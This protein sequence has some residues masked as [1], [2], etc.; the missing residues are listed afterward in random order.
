MPKQ[1]LMPDILRTHLQSEMI[2]KTVGLF[3]LKEVLGVGNT[4]VT[5]RADDSYG[6]P[7]AIKMVTQVSYG[8]RAPLREIAR[9]AKATDERFLVFPKEVGNYSLT[10]RRKTHEF[11]WFRSRI[12]VGETLKA[13]LESNTTFSAKSEILSF[14]ENLTVAID[15]LQKL[16]FSHGD[17][18]DR[19]IMR[20]VIGENGP[21]PEVRYVVIDFSEAHALDS[22]EEGL[23]KD[24]ENLGRHLRGFF[25]AVSQRQ[26]VTRGDEKALAAIAHIPGLLH[27]TAPESMGITKASDV[28]DRFKDGLRSAE[29]A[30]RVL[31]TPFD[32]L[33]SE[34][35]ANNALLAD[36]CFTKSWWASE[37]E[38]NKN[39]LLIGPRGCGKTMIFRRLRLKTKIAAKKT[40]EVKSDPYVGFYL[41]CESLF[42]MRF[43]DLSEAGIDDYKEA[44]ILFFNMAVLAEICSTLAELPDYMAPVPHSAATSIAKLLKEEI[45]PLWED[46]R[47]PA[48]PP[49]LWELA[50]SADRVMR[51]IRRSIAYGEPIYPRGSTEFVSLLVRAVKRE[52][53]SL[54]GRCFTFF[55]DDYTEERVPIGL[56]EALHPIISQRSA[57]I[58]FK[59]SAHM[60]GSI[61]SFPRPLALDEGRNII[62]INL[63]SAYLNLDKRKKQG[64]LLLKILDERFRHCDG[65]EGQTE[66]WL[67]KTTYPDG[68]TLARTLHDEDTRNKFHYHGVDCLMELCTGDYSEMIRMVGDIFR[69]AGVEPGEPVRTISPYL[70]DKAITRVSREFLGRIRHIRPD[71][72]KLF[73]VVYNFG[74]LSQRLL[75]ER[76]PVGQGLDRKGQPRKDPYDLLTVY[77]DNL[78]KALRSARDVWERLQRA[79]IF[80]DIGLA[81]SQRTI[82]ADRATLRRIYCPAFRTTL[83]SSEHLQATKDQFEYFMDKPE[84]FCKKYFEGATNS[85]DQRKLWGDQ[86]TAEPKPLDGDGSF[87]PPEEQDKVDFI[88][89]API[90]W[91]QVVNR[92]PELKPVES[93]IGQKSHFNLYI[94]AMGFEERT[95]EAV[96]ALVR[97][98]ITVDHAVLFEFDRFYEAAE[99]RRNTYEKLIKGLT[100]GQQYR[101]LNAPVGAPDPVFSERMK[102]VLVTL[103]GTTQPSILFDCTSCPSLILSEA[104]KVLLDYSCDLTILYSEAAEY[105]PTLSDWEAGKPRPDGGRVQG[106]FAGVRFVA[107]PAVLQADDTGESPVLLV[108]FPTFNT[109]RTD[110]V[111]A[112]LEPE[113]R[114]WLFGEPHDL[115]KH[116]YRIEMAKCFA[117]P[118]M[119]PGDQWSTVSTFDYRDTLL[120]L[121]GVYAEHRI[122]HRLAIMPHGSK[123]QTLGVSLFASVHQVSMVFA[124]P[125]TYNTNRYS[126]GCSQVWAIQLGKTKKL[127]SALRAKRALG[128]PY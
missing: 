66:D 116:S 103:A 17:L 43:S 117:S 49:N 30:P 73:D 75:Y 96:A 101:P 64:K 115:S 11:I 111:L 53:S 13:F 10:L 71:G 9:F 122:R 67:G 63:G 5:Y 91:K 87:Q 41:P 90:Q 34:N 62:V 118:I 74:R 59:I 50:E 119:Y 22:T 80:V 20:E 105:Y 35:I 37:L 107:K 92:L 7:W 23:S 4:A 97:Q 88:S 42:F 28:L 38:N 113:A 84:E 18:H 1:I 15:E 78:T 125:K 99:K 27:G 95:T 98:N 16:G 26:G 3:K 21:L 12:V 31:R 55:L 33:S 69:E 104:L 40:T 100:G 46:L 82:V 89:R 6:V 127:L 48:T 39:V 79:S 58:C 123:M 110:G 77:V 93:A 32:S 8:D 86:G 52:V 121:G 106:P 126:N 94:G 85:Q 128:A 14:V 60:F 44:L 81:P 36:L 70:Q 2:G 45:G 109:E 124:M 108:M 68:K 57:S 112:E 54:S 19:N 102:S 24:I 120:E 61:Y 56:Q 65:Y 51:S 114:I 83:T 47:L 76:E 72:Q 25:D 29:E